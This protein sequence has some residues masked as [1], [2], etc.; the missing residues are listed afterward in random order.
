MQDARFVIL[1]GRAHRIQEPL[2]GR[3]FGRL[4]QVYVEARF[5][6][7]SGSTAPEE[8]R[9]KALEIARPI[10]NPDQLSALDAALAQGF[11]PL[12]GEE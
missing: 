10:L 8:W 6:R 12:A 7:Q 4:D 9:D 5:L 2:K 1:R 3:R 11:R